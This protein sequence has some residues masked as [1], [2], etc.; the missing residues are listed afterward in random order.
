MK[1][2]NIRPILSVLL[3][4]GRLSVDEISKRSG[5]GWFDTCDVLT[6]LS[7]YGIARGGDFQNDVAT[8]C[9]LLVRGELDHLDVLAGYC[10]VTELAFK[11]VERDRDR[12]RSALYTAKS[13]IEKSLQQ[14]E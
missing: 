14:G 9:T 6:K 10:R 7:A 8:S 12:L 3:V 4:P 5:V 13:A 1:I 2:E 11:E